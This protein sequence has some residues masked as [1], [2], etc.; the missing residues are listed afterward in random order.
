MLAV[1]HLCV[2]PL[3]LFHNVGSYIFGGSRKF[4]EL[5][6]VL[7]NRSSAVGRFLPKSEGHGA[8]AH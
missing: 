8:F 6:E 2:S 1:I 7:R 3:L 4:D 5:N